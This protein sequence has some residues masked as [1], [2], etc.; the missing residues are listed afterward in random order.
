MRINTLRDLV[1]WCDDAAASSLAG[2]PPVQAATA[3]EDCAG[4][5][6]RHAHGQGLAA[7]DDW[8]WV[9]EMYDSGRLAEIVRE[10]IAA[11]R[12]A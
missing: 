5:I 8:G 7:G 3:A 6:W 11:H 2:L 1:R 4:V 12:E 9:L 10:S